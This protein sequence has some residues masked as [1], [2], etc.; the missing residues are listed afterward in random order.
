MPY[1]LDIPALTIATGGTAAPAFTT[2]G[3][4]STAAGVTSGAT[5]ALG[6][7]P[8]AIGVAGNNPTP[9][10][11]TLLEVVVSGANCPPIYRYPLTGQRGV[12]AWVT[13]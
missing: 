7:P 5:V 6:I 11:L 9:S 4:P 12:N 1:A 8:L 3:F 2:G 13:A 10:V